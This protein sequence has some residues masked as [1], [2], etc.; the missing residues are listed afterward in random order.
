MR[1][2]VTVRGVPEVQRAL[3][4]L[5]DAVRREAAMQVLTEAAEPIAAAARSRAP[6]RTGKLR[7][8]IVVSATA[9]GLAIR[10]SVAGDA[11]TVFV[12]STSS[13]AHFQEYGT[14]HHGAQPFMRP[15][16]DA[17]G[18]AAARTIERELLGRLMA[19]A[20]RAR[21]RTR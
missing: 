19:A 10:G 15:A 11:A 4:S 7:D 13:L 2:T 9:K 21:V 6:V 18:Q 3:E 5:P 1:I 16:F 20:R 8:S 14:A 12:G 17:Q